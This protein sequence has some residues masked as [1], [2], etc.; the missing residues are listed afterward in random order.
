MTIPVNSPMS[1]KIK[2]AIKSRL[3]EAGRP[4]NSDGTVSDKY[5][6]GK[7]Y[8]FFKK[9]GIF[10]VND[11]PYLTRDQKNGVPVV[12]QTCT[13]DMIDSIIDCLEWFLIDALGDG[14][15]D[16]IQNMI[17]KTLV[18]A[19]SADGK[20]N[21][22]S[23]AV[24]SGTGMYG[25]PIANEVTGAMTMLAH[26]VNPYDIELLPRFSFNLPSLSPDFANFLDAGYIMP[27]WEFIRKKE[28]SSNKFYHTGNKEDGLIIGTNINFGSMDE[29]TVSKIF[30]IN[31]PD[32]NGFPTGDAVTGIDAETFNILKRVASKKGKDALD[33][34]DDENVSNI[35]LTE[36]QMIGSFVRYAE[37]AYW[38]PLQNPKNWMNAHWGSL[39]NNSCLSGVRTGVMSYVINH[40]SALISEKTS[41]SALI[42][43]CV[44]MG[45]HYHSGYEFPVVYS[46]LGNVNGQIDDGLYTNTANGEKKLVYNSS[47]S[48]A[49]IS[50]DSV[51]VNETTPVIINK[52]PRNI[53]KAGIYY[54][55]AADLIARRSYTS[56]LMTGD[57]HK[58]RERRVEEANKIYE[59]LGIAKL[60]FAL[61]PSPPFFPS[62]HTLSSLESRYFGSLLNSIIYRYDQ[63][64][65]PG[66]TTHGTNS[67]GDISNIHDKNSYDNYFAPTIKHELSSNLKSARLWD[68]VLMDDF[69]NELELNGSL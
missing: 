57:A 58:L 39:G 19:I 24:A 46:H 48:Q 40:G 36:K 12:D 37:M 52:V 53:S 32:E 18:K 42:S 30:V 20:T 28:G 31:G 51:L 16:V 54:T 69:K 25:I 55:L 7:F 29:E 47:V 61:Y 65:N 60:P 34:L 2:D 23:T 6:K 22:L 11:S 26:G 27:D 43:Y 67:Y 66:T 64:L 49:T 15:G 4:R 5:T 14:V 13:S 68:A 50:G 41:I 35:R 17:D 45:V 38:K 62:D 21:Q 10:D 33:M 3:E 63:I 9:H 8:D 56:S 1:G 44:E 59:E